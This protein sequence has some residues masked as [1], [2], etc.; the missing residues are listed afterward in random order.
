MK[1]YVPNQNLAVFDLDNTLIDSKR[2]LRK[3]VMTAFEG[4][5]VRI[6]SEESKDDWYEV[7]RKYGFTKEQFDNAFDKRKSWEESLGD[8]EIP[9]FPETKQCL[10]ELAD[11]NVEMGLISKSLPEY[12]QTKLDFFDLGKYFNAIETVH[13]EE[14]SKLLAAEKIVNQNL[15]PTLRAYFIGDSEGDVKIASDIRDKYNLFT[16]GIYV[17]RKGEKIGGYENA[18]NLY[19]VNNRILKN[20]R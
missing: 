9:I 13:P 14:G 12:T 16:Q 10:E 5:G 7:A 17:N 18:R 8:G 3:D 11:K 2:K 6:S 19:E 20:E 4:L 1:G 15:K